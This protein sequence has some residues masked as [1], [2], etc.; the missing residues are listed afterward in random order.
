MKH[1]NSVPL[2][3]SFDVGPRF[4]AALIVAGSLW[5]CW[6]QAWAAGGGKPATKLGN[7]ADTRMLGPGLSRW[8]A[9]LYNTSYWLYALAVVVIMAGMGL[10]LGLFSDRLIAL[11]G[12]KL[13]RHDHHE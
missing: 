1:R 8:A 4:R 3:C 13:G 5:I 2:L 6:E 10:L 7:V 11:T 9:D 12:V